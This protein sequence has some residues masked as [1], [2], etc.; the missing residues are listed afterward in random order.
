M[1]FSFFAQG[2]IQ[3]ED[4]VENIY[5][6]VYEEKRK[7]LLDVYALAKNHEISCCELMLKVTNLFNN[8]NSGSY[9]QDRAI[10][11]CENKLLLLLPT[12]HGSF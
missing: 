2:K 4:C 3:N 10:S 5:C 9:T 11:P 8:P 6:F 12:F 7:R 1:R